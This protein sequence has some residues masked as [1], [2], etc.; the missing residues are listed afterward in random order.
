MGHAKWILSTVFLAGCATL[1]PAP[2]RYSLPADTTLIAKPVPPQR[3][4]ALAD[5]A[6]FGP[7]DVR[8]VF[9]APSLDRSEGPMRILQFTSGL[10]VTDMVFSDAGNLTHVE[11]RAK[12]GTPIDIQPCLD[13]FEQTEIYSAGK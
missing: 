6:S 13:S 9:G 12:T 4:L 2:P 11:A 5:L 10:C 3:T 7:E 8:S 1:A